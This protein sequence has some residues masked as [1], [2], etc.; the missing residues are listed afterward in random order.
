MEYSNCHERGTKKKSES[1][2]GI[3]PMTS[4]TPVVKSI[5]VYL[6]KNKLL[7]TILWGVAH[8]ISNIPEHCKT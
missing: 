5:I 1:P 8:P 3:E 4:R 6:S 7:L 2:T